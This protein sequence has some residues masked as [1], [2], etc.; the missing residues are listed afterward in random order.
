MRRRRLRGGP[1]VLAGLL[2]GVL[3]TGSAAGIRAIR[4]DQ[5]GYRPGDPK[6]ALAAEA[7]GPF[8]VRPIDGGPAAFEGTAGPLAPPD[9]ASGDRVATLDF[10]GLR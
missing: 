7:R 6:L 8:S 2:L 9:P 4:V 1:L 5:L 10:T 3:G